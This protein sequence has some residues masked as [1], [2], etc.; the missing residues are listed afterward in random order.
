MKSRNKRNPISDHYAAIDNRKRF[1]MS[2]KSATARKCAPGRATAL[3]ASLDPS[4]PIKAARPGFLLEGGDDIGSRRKLPC[5]P[6]FAAGYKR[7]HP[8]VSG[9]SVVKEQS[10]EFSRRTSVVPPRVTTMVLDCLV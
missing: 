6:A 4:A 10:A 8:M 9:A 3:R 1:A 2:A 5:L 7:R